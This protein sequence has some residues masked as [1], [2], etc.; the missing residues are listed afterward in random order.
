MKDFPFSRIGGT[1]D[2]VDLRDHPYVPRLTFLPAEH[3]PWDT[4][5][6]DENLAVL[7]RTQQGNSCVGHALA[8]V[9]DIQSR[10]TQDDPGDRVSAAM[11]YRMACYYDQPDR[12][13]NDTGVRSLRS[14]IKAFFH[15]G[16]CPEDSWPDRD[17][18]SGWPSDAQ[19]AAASHCTLGAYNRLQPI[20]HHYHCAIVE[21]GAVLVT[22]ETHDGW[23]RPDARGV[24]PSDFGSACRGLHAVAIV[25][26]NRDGFLILNS[27]G[28]GWG[29]VPA[30]HG[31]NPARGLAIWTYKDWARSVADGWVLRLGVPGPEA[32][33]VSAGEQGIN[34]S[35]SKEAQLA[36]PYRMLRGHFLNLDAGRWQITGAYATPAEAAGATVDRIK[37]NVRCDGCDGV[38]LALPGVFE[39]EARAFANAVRQRAAFAAKNLD[40]LTCF[41]SSNVAVE[42]KA[43]LND[44]FARCRE[45]AGGAGGSLDALFE[46]MAR[47]AGRAF[48]RDIEHHAYCAAMPC[49]PDGALWDD[50]ARCQDGR[51]SLGTA[52][53]DLAQVCAE[54]R[55]PLH[56]LAN[57]TGALV[58]DALL[59]QGRSRTG[60]TD[61]RDWLP[62]LGNLVLTFPAVP[63]DQAKRRIIPLAEAMTQD[64]YGSAC[65][66]VPSK[67][68]EDRLST[69]GYGRSILKL[70]SR[71]FLD[72]PQPMLGS[73]PETQ[74]DPF[75]EPFESKRT[76]R[77]DQ[78]EL[79]D[80]PELEAQVIGAITTPRR[81]DAR[82]RSQLP[83]SIPQEHDMDTAFS[84]KI[85]L[86][87]LQDRITDNALTPEE[88]DHYLMI[89]EE[90]S[91]P[92][93]P[94]LVINPDT[95][96]MPAS[97]SRSALAL[98]SANAA[99][100]W[101]RRAEYDAK[102]GGGYDD[103]RIA[104][105]GDSWFQ[106]PLRLYDVIDYVADRYAVFDTSAAGD[107]LENMA[108]KREY[109]D[110]LKH[111]RADI[112]LLSAGGNDVCAG[113][114][115]ALHL[116]RYDP[117]L[118][119]ADYLKR[120]YQA[121][122]DNAIASYERIC[123][124]VNR[125]FPHVSIIVHGYDYVIPANGRW[126]G[127]PMAKC[128]ITERGLQKDIAAEMI[129]GFN[130]ALRRMANGLAHVAYVDCRNSVGDANWYDE[131]HPSAGGFAKVASKILTRINEISDRQ[132]DKLRTYGAKVPSAR[133]MAATGSRAYGLHVGLNAVDPRHYADN[134][135]ALLGCENDA[136]AMRDLAQVEGYRSDILLT[137]DATREAV[138][139]GL[140][141]AAR[142]LR[143]GD[144][145]VFTIA[146]HG[147]QVM[148]RN[149]DEAEMRNRNMDS[150]MCLFDGQ[151]IDD[152]LWNIFTH[153]DQG[154]RI[155]MIADTCH[156]GTMARR[157]PTLDHM[158]AEGETLV[159]RRPRHLP[160]ALAARVEEQNRDF[161]E[162]IA[163]EVP[164]VSRA[165]LA[166]P[167]RSPV[168]ASIIQF[169]A[170][171]DEQEALDGPENGAFTEALL[172][173]WNQ[174][175][176]DGSY[177]KLHERV[178]EEM[179][180]FNQTPR[181][182]LPRGDDPSFLRQRPFSVLRESEDKDA[183]DERQPTKP[184]RNDHSSELDDGDDPFE[185]A[186]DGE[187][188]ADW[189]PRSSGGGNAAP[190]VPNAIV[191]RFRDFIEPAGLV[192]FD[193]AEFLVLGSGHFNTGPAFGLN[194]A[195]PESL[196]P[197]IVP[198]ARVLDELRERLDAPIR[199][200]SAYRSPA[201]NAAIG[202]KQHSWHVQF[203]AC[204]ITVDGVSVS[205]VADTLMK[206]R[207]EKIFL[208]GI[209]RYARFTHVDTRG[210]NQNWS[211][212]K[213]S[214]GRKGTNNHALARLRRIAD[215][216]PS[217]RDRSHSD[218]SDPGDLDQRLYSATA[219]LNGPEVM[220]LNH[221]LSPEQRRAVLYSTQFAQRAADAAADRMTDRTA[222]WTTY[223]AALAAVGWTITGSVARE[224]AAKDL[225]A[226]VD[227]MVLELMG[228]IVAPGKLRAIRA[229]LDGMRSLADTDQRMVVLDREST[230]K[231]GGAIQIGEAEL[232]ND[233]LS[234]TT[235]AIQFS[236]SDAR[237]QILFTRWGK[238]AQQLW[239]AAER[240]V[241]NEDFY[242]STAQA[243]VE[244]RLGDAASRIL[245]FDLA[246]ARQSA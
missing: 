189:Q 62:G 29:G 236:A 185:M 120:S 176:F 243:I 20:L 208:G 212:R 85:T 239:L 117:D 121:V 59:M 93:S 65:I 39:G 77:I 167:T 49:D 211:E 4:L 47:G 140:H 43:V 149:S 134:D 12:A 144:Q 184:P 191:E 193:A 45:R 199:I 95:V 103:L 112:L 181:L 148:D 27:W 123:R 56:L 242:A 216:I 8:A 10:L 58:V 230:Y 190:G 219:A 162:R 73:Y 198:T 96:E 2:G 102:I 74:L 55:K 180:A 205:K 98:N 153:F 225:G 163:H 209:G 25:G 187:D 116:E 115:L 232:D 51:G 161:Y 1:Q 152:E 127:K 81:G 78:Q 41:W 241:L 38:V 110:A 84:P 104:A 21:A 186:D 26:Y 182:F 31:R 133:P 223:N 197:N 64:R 196:W 23:E 109:I 156:S 7:V 90:A 166:S 125:H 72:R 213:L 35:Q 145:F 16:V 80:D 132:A 70:V 57:G 71:S 68:L 89:D 124:D 24:I 238:S 15:H 210:V 100:R 177:R 3:M 154:V 229:V 14:A 173:I 204:D 5:L 136:R 137:Q 217:A 6:T 194:T 237:K 37:D 201:Y 13:G 222:W 220:A 245:A 106:Y 9:I 200:T 32:F 203:R 86:K 19:A 192:H 142:D 214:S 48:W 42:M 146:G 221:G 30:P 151:F 52:V 82:S 202:G 50:N 231:G 33:A 141:R 147:S 22:A 79:E 159:L 66:I 244:E 105:E 164:H 168:R 206:M 18:A 69:S 67:K 179:A 195:P 11:L 175:K 138:M 54:R 234:V 61:P 101:L 88:L 160:L 63:M 46:H 215:T 75:L 129:D 207:N 139:A 108:A 83:T 99:A 178:A 224:A 170:C 114:N 172:R 76:Y 36:V 92:F 122:L 228:S 233:Q 28:P 158:A 183:G 135:G 246:I 155:V 240:L 188:T 227:V 174:G 130:R 128:G 111:S 143:D 131:L 94:I 226:T 87:E 60:S 113:G 97:G 91:S 40:F 119:P 235:G 126:L 17:I 157:L 118:K 171:L 169:A 150:T 53:M 165:I 34:R 218:G 107:L 44:I